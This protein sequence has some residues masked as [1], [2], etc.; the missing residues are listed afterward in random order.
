MSEVVIMKRKTEGTDHKFNK[1]IKTNNNEC[2]ELT[3]IQVYNDSIQPIRNM[4]IRV[5]NETLNDEWVTKNMKNFISWVYTNGGFISDIKVSNNEM[6]NKTQSLVCNSIVDVVTQKT[7]KTLCL[8]RSSLG[9]ESI[10]KLLES[11]V[12]YPSVTTLCL[13]NNT[14][15]ANIAG[16]LEEYLKSS[17]SLTKLCLANNTLGSS[18]AMLAQVLLCGHLKYLNLSNIQLKDNEAE[19][20]FCS[21]SMNKCSLQQLILENNSITHKGLKIWGTDSLRHNTSLQLLDLAGNMISDMGLS[22][23][24]WGLSKNSTVKILDISQN[25]IN[26]TGAKALSDMLKENSVVTCLNLSYNNI[27]RG[28]EPIA[29]IL[30]LNTTLKK[31]D[32]QWNYI[33]SDSGNVIAANIHKMNLTQLNVS[34]NMMDSSIFKILEQLPGN[35]ALLY[36]DLSFNNNTSTSK[37]PNGITERFPLSFKANSLLTL[38]LK[39]NAID[40]GYWIII[41]KA[42]AQNLSITELDISSNEVGQSGTELVKVLKQ[43]TG[44]TNVTYKDTNMDK[45]LNDEVA[46][47]LDM[48]QHLCIMS[49]K[50]VVLDHYDINLF[51][52]DE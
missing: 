33:N 7:L 51:Y 5:E 32:L 36:L 13:A 37:I 4:S 48:N 17:T 14:L 10:N 45:S 25:A 18:A 20:I 26:A 9:D 35:K 46:K 40:L 42:L 50:M 30:T 24:S 21:L 1:K 16:K 49:Q 38:N 12:K 2:I 39:S 22:Y 27:G 15:T 41:F 8:S 23:I 52:Q 43:N 11:L 19:K 6:S 47:L 31:L 34:G 3:D 28:V 29:K 44:L